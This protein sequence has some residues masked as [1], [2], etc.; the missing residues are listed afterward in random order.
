MLTLKRV[1]REC[2]F[3]LTPEIAHELI[4]VMRSALHAGQLAQQEQLWLI[5]S[6]GHVLG[7]I[8]A[9]KCITE[10]ES[11]IGIYLKVFFCSIDALLI[12]LAIERNQRQYTTSGQTSTGQYCTR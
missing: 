6:I 12:L 3:S 1:T 7:A 2:R 4:V 9:D 10:L 5:Q 11:L 8:D